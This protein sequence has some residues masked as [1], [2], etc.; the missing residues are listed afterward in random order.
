M[1]DS[2][3]NNVN[4]H[5]LNRVVE[6]SATRHIEASEDV[7]NAVGM[8]LIAKGARISAEMQERLLRHKLKKPLESSLAVEGGVHSALL[9]DLAERVINSDVKV[10]PIL[11][12]GNHAVEARAILGSLPLSGPVSMLLTLLQKG[13]ENELLHAVEGA[14]VGL[15]LGLQAGVPRAN[16]PALA[17]G[18]LLHDI[19]ELYINPEYLRSGASLK[20]HEWRH[21]A[22]HPLVGRMLVD[23]LGQFPPLAG[24]IVLEHHERL[25]GSG[26]PRRIAGDQLSL[27]GLIVGVADTICAVFRHYGK[28]LA[29][30]EI[31]MRIVPGQFPL[32]VTQIVNLALRN[33]KPAML[34]GGDL[35]SAESMAE[36]MHQLLRRLAQVLI[37]LDEAEDDDRVQQFKPALLLAQRAAERVR[38]IQLAFSSTGL[39]SLPHG[40]HLQWLQQVDR[41]LLFEVI[42]AI[43]EIAWRLR[44]LGRD[45]QLRS[46]D[47]PED[48]RSVFVPLIDALHSAH[49]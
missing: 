42:V 12:I 46:E 11:L 30:A 31:A 10:Q 25:D 1:H 15:V 14:M 44:E 49:G 20:P 6:L 43:E 24:Q 27:E 7:Y 34:E 36:S 5:Y 48:V 35:P 29:R 38:L 19:G 2:P 4:P 16:L 32:R 26:Y 8:K 9:L 18:A 3:L 33:A 13:G 17:A 40:E 21:V 41:D 37:R 47:L 22:S 45:L 39:D 28:P 23:E